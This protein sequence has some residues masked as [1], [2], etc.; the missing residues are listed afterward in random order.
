MSS[1][2]GVTPKRE[3]FFLI[4]NIIIDSWGPII[5]SDGVAVYCLLARK[6]NSETGIAWMGQ[7]WIADHLGLSIATVG[8]VLGDL[9]DLGLITVE[10]QR[11]PAT[12]RVKRSLY[13]LVDPVPS[14]TIKVED[15]PRFKRIEQRKSKRA[16]MPTT[17]SLDKSNLNGLDKTTLNGSVSAQLTIT[18][19]K[20]SALLGH[21]DS[22][23]SRVSDETRPPAAEPSKK[24]SPVPA[25][26]TPTGPEQCAAP[27]AAPTT[28]DDVP[29]APAEARRAGRKWTDE[30]LDWYEALV[31][32]TTGWTRVEFEARKSERIQKRYHAAAKRLRE[33][34][35]HTTDLLSH[36]ERGAWWW[37][38]HWLGKERG[39]WPTVETIEDTWGDWLKSPV[40]V[41]AQAPKYPAYN[42]MPEDQRIPI[43]QTAPFWFLP[44]EIR[45]S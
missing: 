29:A 19:Y 24:E 27:P 3:K 36:Y 22:M 34:G 6:A 8:T 28:W 35:Y 39:E 20:D 17:N 41:E 1:E 7:D 2:I 16:S 31:R 18:E 13:T 26:D 15:A 33:A 10:R 25:K 21:E 23:V 44:G 30:H 40:V 42:P 43:P 12:G 5:A 38:D 4:Q 45:A 9:E 14:P 32:V 11:D 37:T